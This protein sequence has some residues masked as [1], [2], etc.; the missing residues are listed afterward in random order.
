MHTYASLNLVQNYIQQIRN[1]SFEGGAPYRK[2]FKYDAL[3]TLN[4]N[5]G[6]IYT[7]NL[8]Q[9]QQHSNNIMSDIVTAL[10]PGRKLDSL[11][12]FAPDYVTVRRAFND[13]LVFPHLEAIEIEDTSKSN[14]LSLVTDG[15]SRFS[16]LSNIDIGLA[17]KA[18]SYDAAFS[19]LVG[20]L[21]IQLLVMTLQ[22][23][24]Q[25]Y[26]DH[27]RAESE[28]N[29]KFFADVSH[30]SRRSIYPC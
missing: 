16:E 2:W 30:V 28:V 21:N 5:R 9:T 25:E 10:G 11:T 14:L 12:S 27:A 3:Q 17:R 19:A 7:S 15:N 20:A 23:V 1:I 29:L 26:A 24:A 13:L 22:P 4:V 18:I 6:T 8:S